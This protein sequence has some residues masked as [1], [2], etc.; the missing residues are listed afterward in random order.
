[1]RFDWSNP[2]ARNTDPETSHEAAKQVSTTQL[3]DIIVKVFMKAPNGLTADEL[4][5]RLPTFALNSLTPRIAPLIRKGYLFASG[6]RKGKSGK[7]QRV[8]YYAD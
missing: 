7:S 5:D 2:L 4:S 1:M 8:V 3:E 6:K